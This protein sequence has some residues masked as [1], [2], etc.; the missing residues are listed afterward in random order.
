MAP[1]IEVDN[2]HMS[3]GA[4]EVLKGVSFHVNKGETFVIMGQSGH[5]K[6][7]TLGVILGLLCPQEGKVIVNGE[8]VTCQRA[9]LKFNPK[10]R[11]G[12]LFQGGALFDSLTVGENVAFYLQQHGTI[13]GKTIYKKDIEV[14][15][16]EALDLVGLPGI[17][18]KM[19]SDLSG[20]MRKRVALARVMIYK[21]D[22]I[23]Y[24]EPTTGLDPVNS[25]KISELIVDLQK[26]FG[27]T[28]V[29]V[30]HDVMSALFVGDWMALIE[31]G[32]I[33][34]SERPMAF[35]KSELHTIEF[36]RNMIGNNL[37]LVRNRDLSP[38]KE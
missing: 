29:V 5:G 8:N 31:N 32:V 13:D 35:M 25:Q 7:V 10:V 9:Q 22:C 17:E 11:L 3:F 27:I 24:D 2:L 36:F 21:P 16:R 6:S 26:K 18:N 20:G 34:C 19:P 23:L 1:M 4:H 12:M 28:S 37:E 38:R 15:V 33:K 30:T 14:A